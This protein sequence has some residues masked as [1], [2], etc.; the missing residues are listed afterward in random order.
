MQTS[1]RIFE[2]T[3]WVKEMSFCGMRLNL[4]MQLGYDAT[5]NS[6]IKQ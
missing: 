4:A 2:I 5:S 3:Q 6:Y 1:A